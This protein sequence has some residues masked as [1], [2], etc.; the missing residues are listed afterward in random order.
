[1]EP[2]PGLPELS[3]RFVVR[4]W[5]I[6]QLL[7][8]ALDARLDWLSAEEQP[9]WESFR[10]AERRRTF[11]AGRVAMKECLRDVLGQ[12]DA[13]S[14]IQPS[15]IYI[16]SRDARGRPSRPVAYVNG[17]PLPITLS[18]TH[19]DETVVVGLAL[20]AGDAI[21]VDLTPAAPLGA[22]FQQTWFTAA[23][24]AWVAESADPL[25]AARLWSAKE[26][27]YK[28]ANQ[29]EPFVPT[30]V[31]IFAGD[32]AQWLFRLL[33]RELPGS[34]TVQIGASHGQILAIA[35]GSTHE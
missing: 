15:S 4:D 16:E 6:D 3:A 19:S 14:T 2:T 5:P 11:L 9:H 29:G 21:G 34:W 20:Q 12:R 30:Q 22:G 8:P 35:R 28:A 33:D 17:V 1:M 18:L 25:R 27:V 31:E 13:A 7:G 10:S 26:A 23:E 32:H 24:R